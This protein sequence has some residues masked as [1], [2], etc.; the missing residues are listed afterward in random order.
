MSKEQYSTLSNQLSSHFSMG[1]PLA[2]IQSNMLPLP[3]MPG[4]TCTSLSTENAFQFRNQ[5]LATNAEGQAVFAND[6]QIVHDLLQ[7]DSGSLNHTVAGYT[8]TTLRNETDT[9]MVGQGL[10]AGLETKVSSSRYPA[11]SQYLV[12]KESL[13]HHFGGE[14]GLTSLTGLNGFCETISNAGTYLSDKHSLHSAG[15]DTSYFSVGCSVIEDNLSGRISL[16]KGLSCAQQI[17]E[18]LL[19]K[20]PEVVYP[21]HDTAVPGPIPTDLFQTNALAQQKKTLSTASKSDNLPSDFSTPSCLSQGGDYSNVPSIQVSSRSA[22]NAI[23]P[24]TNILGIA[25]DGKVNYSGDGQLLSDV[26]LFDGMDLDLRHIFQG[27]GLWDDIF[28]TVENGDHQNLSIDVSEN[29]SEFDKDGMSGNENGLFS[30]FGL[31]RIL[32]SIGDGKVDSSTSHSSVITSVKSAN[33]QE[34]ENQFSA[35]SNLE[36]TPSSSKVQQTVIPCFSDTTDSLLTKGNI[37]KIMQK[38]SEEQ[39]SECKGGPWIDDSYSMNA[40]NHFNYQP[41]KPEESTKIPKKR[42]R[43]GESTRPRPKDRQ[44]IQDRVKELREIVPNGA[45]CSIDALLARTVNHM[46]FLQGVIKYA[47]KIKQAD[48]PKMIGEETGVILRDSQSNGGGATWAY[49]VA[50]QTLVCPITIKELNPPGQMLI[51]IL[52][53]DRGSFLEIADSIRSFGL[54]IL[55]GVMEAR[56]KKIWAHFLVEANQD[57]TRMEIFL[58]LV[59]LLTRTSG[60]GPNNDHTAN[61]IDGGIP[62]FSNYQHSP[63]PIPIG[64]A[65]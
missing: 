11:M 36:N 27:E 16:P 57:V 22:E 24:G 31:R 47:D 8:R 20:F 4:F 34:T 29:T 38:P 18:M 49:E 46:L 63:M 23:T 54:T 9:S 52:C 21:G 15:L 13:F 51:E 2:S 60:V 17:P 33:N 19:S 28:M 14:A 56:D 30:E 35:S 55:K 26:D 62:M 12:P 45:K 48:E 1:H 40:D 64:L 7:S 58:H 44:Q 61:I 43:P 65:D 42:A 37:E 3:V 10:P 53:E 59:Q 25:C 32:D 39:L 41:E 6:A 5:F 50:G